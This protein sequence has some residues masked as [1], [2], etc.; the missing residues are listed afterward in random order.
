MEAVVR[1]EWKP[2][3]QAGLECCKGSCGKGV[4]LEPDRERQEEG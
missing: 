2:V 4:H 3:K 1:L